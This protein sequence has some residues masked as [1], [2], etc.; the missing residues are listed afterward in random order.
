SVQKGRKVYIAASD[1]TDYG[2]FENFEL[3]TGLACEVVVVD[4]LQLDHKIEQL[5]DAAG[6]L[7]LSE[8]EF[9]EFAE[10][11]SEPQKDHTPK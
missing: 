1:P 10:L 6:S 7:N 2:A 11:D 3:S 9:K 5:L 4:Y 8:D